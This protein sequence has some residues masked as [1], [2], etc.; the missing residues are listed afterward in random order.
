M[1][2]RTERVGNVIRGIVAEA[3]QS[4][5]NDPRIEPMTSV[6]Y[7]DLTPDFAVA[8]VHVSVMAAPAKQRATLAGL[9]AAKHRIR[10]LVKQGLAA[11]TIPQLEFHLDESVQRSL[12]TISQIDDL[13]Q[14]ADSE[15]DLAQD[16]APES[17]TAAES[18][19]E[20]ETT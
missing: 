14:P 17:D 5:L 10:G 13:M 7:V 9:T 12:E 16:P 1:S 2:I 8:H 18:D 4:R 15:D 11:R 19:E 20:Y 6:T 3:I